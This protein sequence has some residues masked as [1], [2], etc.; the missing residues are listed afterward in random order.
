MVRIVCIGSLRTGKNRSTFFQLF[1]FSK[2]FTFLEKNKKDAT[3]CASMTEMLAR[4]Y[5]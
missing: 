3:S 1:P 4:E 5:H 2:T